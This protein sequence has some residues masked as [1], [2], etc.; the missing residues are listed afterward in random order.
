MDIGIAFTLKSVGTITSTTVIERPKPDGSSVWI[1]KFETNRPLPTH[2]L[3][4]LEVARGGPKIF[5]GVQAALNDLKSIGITNTMVQFAGSGSFRFNPFEWLYP[6]VRSLAEQ[7]YDEDRIVSAFSTYE[8]IKLDLA[9]DDDVTQARVVIQH[10]LGQSDGKTLE[11]YEPPVDVL[12][13]KI[14]KPTDDGGWFLCQATCSNSDE[15][16]TF[17]VSGVGEKQLRYVFADHK[18]ALCKLVHWCAH[19][20]IPQGYTDASALQ[21]TPGT[22]TVPVAKFRLDA[23]DI[24][25]I[26]ASERGAATMV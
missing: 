24:Q 23:A 18:A 15:D 2:M 5:K 10:A 25:A 6:W 13:V 1:V 16:F 22:Y 21:P 26:R 3:D 9:N 8:G 4:L 11:K 20:R 17:L 14:I 19:Q 12:D 7:G